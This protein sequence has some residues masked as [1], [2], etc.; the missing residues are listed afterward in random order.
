MGLQEGFFPQH[1]KRR[2]AAQ[3][4]KADE[5]YVSKGRKSKE[6]RRIRRPL[7]FEVRAQ[8]C[9]QSNDAIPRKLH[10][11]DRGDTAA[12]LFLCADD[13]LEKGLKEVDGYREEGGRVVLRRY[14]P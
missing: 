4:Y 11:S 1:P 8:A 13:L 5:D 2:E 6:G 3:K 10:G 9:D 7:W 14:L 12:L